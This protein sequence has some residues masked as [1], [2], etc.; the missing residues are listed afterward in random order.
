MGV[1]ARGRAGIPACAA[2]AVLLA[3]CTGA[4]SATVTVSGTSLTVYTSQPPGGGSS[5]TR[6]TLAAE[7]L[8]L[9]QAGGQ[10]GKFRVRLVKLNGRELSD[11]ARSAIEDKTSIAYLGE[12]EPGASPNS[13]PIT[14]EVDV[15]QVSPTDTAAYLTQASAA[16]D[17]APGKYYPSSKNYGETFARVV[18]T[19]DQEAKALVQA[20]QSLR[21]SK[22]YVT[23]DAQPYGDAIA[24]A[25][26]Q[27]AAS[28]P[29]VVRG[30][31]TVAAF[32]RAHA[33]AI[34]LGTSS[35]ASAAK[36]FAGIAAASPGA[37]LFG[38]S[39]LY[40]DSFVSGLPSA[41][42]RNVYVSSPGFLPADLSPA[43]RKFDSD[44]KAAYGRNPAPAAIF[45]YEAMA[46]V[47]AVIREA[48]PAANVRRD[49][50]QDFRGIKNRPS[51]LGTYSLSDGD[52]NLAP[53]VISRIQTGTLVPF[54]F[55]QIQG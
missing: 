37:K 10:A 35:S 2:L 53:F 20:M 7:Q 22:L 33:D 13:V 55:L 27:D 25:V 11:N 6:D 28:S 31:A 14:N 45:G 18:P 30:P 1:L 39:A 46:A 43:G 54:K 38:P 5:Q 42:R 48:G 21:V 51:A 17:G 3:G 44:F 15:L 4:P 26:A 36:L 8:A 24:A 23:D 41:A 52:T 49:I 34:F 29:T 9:S 50:V 47:L 32:K 12:L 40:A 19:T 16:V